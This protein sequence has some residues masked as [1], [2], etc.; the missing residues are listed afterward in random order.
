MGIWCAV[1]L[2]FYDAITWKKLKG[3]RRSGRRA[4]VRHP[5]WQ[6]LQ[7]SMVTDASESEDSNRLAAQERFSRRLRIH[8]L[9]AVPIVRLHSDRHVGILSYMEKIF[10]FQ[11]G[12]F[13]GPETVDEEREVGFRAVLPFSPYPGHA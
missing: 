3:W 11:V 2:F 12:S 9:N 5:G 8:R 7:S 1:H 10:V 13:G 4:E 6:V